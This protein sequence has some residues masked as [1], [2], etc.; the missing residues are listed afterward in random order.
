MPVTE[1]TKRLKARCR[2]KH[3]S[4]GEFVDESVRTGIERARLITESHKQTT[5]EPRV[6][7]RAKGLANILNNITIIIQEDEL[8]VG[9][10]VE[11]PEAIPLYPELSYFVTLD[12]VRSHYCPD[13]VKAE[14]M[15]IC[16][17]WEPYT[18][19]RKGEAYY[20]PEE[21]EQAY[22][23]ST[24]EAPAFVTGFNSIVP[25]YETVQE[26]G[27]LKRIEII[28]SKI[29]DAIAQLKKTPWNATE[30][31]P[32]LEKINNWRAMI[33][34]DEAVIAWARRHARL[35][36]IIAEI[37]ETDPA[38]KNELMEISDICH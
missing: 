21:L 16:K 32:L 2:W 33:I 5:G 10:H 19:Q 9:D 23:F 28:Q 29:D 24:V 18:L 25:T 27:L 38:R 12:L 4:A 31:L 26:D 30:N 20:T 15:D 6:I 7:R 37:F 36:R 35:A 34:A 14:A 3:T 8:I 22:Q 11:H 17:Y 1:R 13:E